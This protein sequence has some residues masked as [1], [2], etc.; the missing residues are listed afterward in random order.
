MVLL[1]Y[2]HEVMAL[3][4][5]LDSDGAVEVKFSA[6]LEI[7]VAVVME[8]FVLQHGISVDTDDDFEYDRVLTLLRPPLLVG[9]DVDD[10]GLDA[11]QYLAADLQLKHYLTNHQV[12]C[13]YLLQYLTVSSEH[14]DAAVELLEH[15]LPHH[16]LSVIY[17]DA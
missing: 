5:V 11:L 4:M 2:L 13:C 14:I 6:L 8:I 17:E 10:E 15:S 3:E 1:Y 12:F 16:P 7:E 9:F